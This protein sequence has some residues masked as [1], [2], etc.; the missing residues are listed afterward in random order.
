MLEKLKLIEDQQR[1]YQEK[2]NKF[3]KERNNYLQKI[4]RDRSLDIIKKYKE[5]YDFTNKIRINL[6]RV[7]ETVFCETFNNIYNNIFNSMTYQKQ[8]IKSSLQN[9]NI[10]GKF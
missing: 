2:Y 4:N 6:I 3:K 9:E 8:H 7:K 1:Q 5:K 10:L